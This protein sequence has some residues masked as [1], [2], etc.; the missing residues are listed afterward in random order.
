MVKIRPEGAKLLHAEKQKE[1]KNKVDALRNFAEVP[2]KTSL[3]TV[4]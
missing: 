4:S 1:I 3:P 2:N